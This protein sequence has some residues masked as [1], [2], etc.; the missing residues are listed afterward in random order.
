M[1]QRMEMDLSAADGGA[2]PERPAGLRW[3]GVTST[4]RR[5]PGCRSRARSGSRQ[6]AR[7]MLTP[8]MSSVWRTMRRRRCARRWPI[9]RAPM[10]RAAPRLPRRCRAARDHAPAQSRCHAASARAGRAGHHRQPQRPGERGKTRISASSRCSMVAASRKTPRRALR[11]SPRMARVSASMRASSHGSCCG[12]NAAINGT[13]ATA[14]GTMSR[15]HTRS[16]WPA[17]RS[18]P[19]PT[20]RPRASPRRSSAGAIVWRSRAQAMGRRPCRREHG[21]H[22]GL[23]CRRCGGLPRHSRPRPRPRELRARRHHAG[24]H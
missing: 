22:R 11:S 24:A 5:P 1:P 20:G 9:C 19:V 23:V 16:A 8:A 7:R 4:A 14:T 13:A 17:A 21:V 18:R 6:P 15:S 3:R 12:S 2:S 10:T